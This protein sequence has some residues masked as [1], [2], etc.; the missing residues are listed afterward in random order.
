M[1]MQ[2]NRGVRFSRQNHSET[3]HYCPITAESLASEIKTCY[4][5]VDKGRM[6]LGRLY[7]KLR[8]HDDS[9]T[10]GSFKR[11]YQLLIE[12]DNLK[13]ILVSIAEK[14]SNYIRQ[15][16]KAQDIV[17]SDRREMEEFLRMNKATDKR[18]QEKVKIFSRFSDHPENLVTDLQENSQILSELLND[19]KEQLVAEEQFIRNKVRDSI[20]VSPRDRLH[21]IRSRRR[22]NAEWG[23]EDHPRE[24]DLSG[25]DETGYHPPDNKPRRGFESPHAVKDVDSP[26]IESCRRRKRNSFRSGEREE[27]A[28][29]LYEQ[30]LRTYEDRKNGQLHSRGVNNGGDQQPDDCDTS[31]LSQKLKDLVKQSENVQQLISNSNRKAEVDRKHDFETTL[32]AGLPQPLLP[33]E[34]FK[35]SAERKA[36]R[37]T[38]LGPTSV[39]AEQEKN[40][41]RVTARDPPLETKDNNP[42]SKLVKEFETVNRAGQDYAD[43]LQHRPDQDGADTLRRRPDQ[44]GADTLQHRSDQD[45][46]DAL[47]RRSDKDDLDTLQ[48]C[49][50]QDG[51]DTSRRSF[52]NF[53]QKCE[54]VERKMKGCSPKEIREKL[55]RNLDELDRADQ[56]VEGML[57]VPSL[58]RHQGH[59]CKGRVDHEYIRQEFVKCLD[60]IFAME[61]C[62][63]SAGDEIQNLKRELKQASQER[64]AV[65]Q[66]L[67][68]EIDKLKERLHLRANDVD[69]YRGRVYDLKKE[70]FDMKIKY[71]T[72]LAAK[73]EASKEDASKDAHNDDIKS[74]KD[75]CEHLKI[76]VDTKSNEISELRRELESAIE[77]IRNLKQEH[78]TGE[79]LTGGKLTGEKLTGEKV[80]VESVV[81]FEDVVSTFRR[82]NQESI[83][84]ELA[85]LQRV[86]EIA[87]ENQRKSFNEIASHKRENLHLIE[88][89]SKL[90]EETQKQMYRIEEL[91]LALMERNAEID[92]FYR[93][94]L[95]NLKEPEREYNA[96]DLQLKEAEC[97]RLKGKLAFYESMAAE[98]GQ[99]MTARIDGFYEEFVKSL[100]KINKEKEILEEDFQRQRLMY[101]DLLAE[102]HNEIS[103]L[104]KNEK[105]IEKI[106]SNFQPGKREILE[107][108]LSSVQNPE[109]LAEILSRDLKDGPIENRNLV[110]ENAKLQKANAE[111]QQKVEEAEQEVVTFKNETKSLKKRNKELNDKCDHLKSENYLLTRIRQ[112]DGQERL[113]T[114]KELLG[115]KEAECF[116][117]RKILDESIDYE[118][119]DEL[120]ERLREVHRELLQDGTTKEELSL[121]SLQELLEKRDREIR[122]LKR[123]NKLLAES[124]GLDEVG[125]RSILET[126]LATKENLM[127]YSSENVFDSEEKT[128]MIESENR[129]LKRQISGKSEE[130]SK[131]DDE[132]KVLKRS[133]K[134]SDD[135]CKVLEDEN[136][137][138]RKKLRTLQSEIRELD[139]LS[140]NRE[141]SLGDTANDDIIKEKE[142]LSE[143]LL[144]QELDNEK[145]ADEINGLKADIRRYEVEASDLKEKLVA[146]LEANDELADLKQENVEKDEILKDLSKKLGIVEKE[147]KTI[148]EAYIKQKVKN[149]ED[150]KHMSDQIKKLQ[151]EVASVTSK[152]SKSL[153]VDSLNASHESLPHLD[154][155]DGGLNR[156]DRNRLIKK[157]QEENHQQSA[158]ILSLEEET[159]AITKIVAD[160]E[161]GHGHLTGML[162]GHLVLQKDA[163]GKLLEK[164]LQQYSDEFESCKR[165]F[166][167][168]EDR[169]DKNRKHLTR[170]R[171]VWDL[172][173]NATATVDNITAILVEGLIKVEDDL[174]DEFSSDEDFEARD[175]K[176]RLWLLRR[177][178]DDVEKRYRDL[179][180]RA[181]ELSVRLDAKTAEYDVTQDEL[182]DATRVLEVNEITLARLTEELSA[183]AKE[184]AKLK[185]IMSQLKEN[186][187]RTVGA[188]I[189]ENEQLR[190][191][192]DKGAEDRTEIDALQL[193]MKSLQ[194]QLK[195]DDFEVR[196][197]RR[198]LHEQERREKEAIDDLKDKGREEARRY[199]EEA[200]KLQNEIKSSKKKAGESAKRVSEL[201]NQLRKA[202]EKVANLEKYLQKARSSCRSDGIDH[203]ST[204]HML[205]DDLKKLFKE[206][207]GLKDE[208]N[209]KQ[210][211]ITALAKD[212]REAKV[213]VKE[214]LGTGRSF[215]EKVLDRAAKDQIMALKRRI[216]VLE[217]EN[218]K[219]VRKVNNLERDQS[220]GEVT[221]KKKA[222]TAKSSLGEKGGSSSSFSKDEDGGKT[223]DS[224]KIA[225][226]T[227]KSVS[228][229]IFGNEELLDNSLASIESFKDFS[230]ENKEEIEIRDNLIRELEG[231][232]K[233]LKRELAKK[234]EDEKTSVGEK[235]DQTS[236]QVD[237]MSISEDVEV[238]KRE[239]AKL[240]KSLEK[241]K[242]L[243]ISYQVRQKDD[244]IK[245]LRAKLGELDDEIDQKDKKL[246]I[247]ERELAQMRE[248]LGPDWK[249]KEIVL[250]DSDEYKELE[251]QRDREMK[252]LKEEIATLEATC[253]D[254]RIAIE[255]L[256]KGLAVS[257]TNEDQIQAI[258]EISVEGALQNLPDKDSG[259]ADSASKRSPKF[260]AI[261]S[262]EQPASESYGHKGKGV[263]RIPIS[264]RPKQ[265][266]TSPGKAEVRKDLERKVEEQDDDIK[267]LLQSVDYFEKEVQK[268]IEEVDSLKEKLKNSGDEIKLL[269][270]NNAKLQSQLRETK[271][272]DEKLQ[273]LEENVKR[274]NTENKNLEQQ[275]KN[276]R[277]AESERA[278]SPTELSSRKIAS[279]EKELRTN[280]KLMETMKSHIGLF[281]NEL[282][283]DSIDLSDDEKK[284]K[285]VIGESLQKRI[286]R[287]RTTIQADAKRKTEVADKENEKL[288]AELNKKSNSLD[289]HAENIVTLKADLLDTEKE[290]K[291]IRSELEK[292]KDR[293]KWLEAELDKAT[294]RSIALEAI[295]EAVTHS[296]DLQ[297]VERKEKIAASSR[298]LISA[299]NDLKKVARGVFVMADE[300][301]LPS[302]T[303]EEEVAEEIDKMTSLI[304]GYS[305]NVIDE[306]GE[307]R[308]ANFELE[309]RV[310]EFRKIVEETNSKISALEEEVSE[311]DKDDEIG[312]RLLIDQITAL[313]KKVENCEKDKRSIEDEAQRREEFIERLTGQVKILEK[314]IAQR[315]TENSE[316]TE[317]ALDSEEELEH[318]KT[319]IEELE[320]DYNRLLHHGMKLDNEEAE[321]AAKK[322]EFEESL[323]KL[324]ATIESLK[325][326][327]KYLEAK[328]E[329]L[330]LANERKN[331]SG[332]DIKS[333]DHQLLKD[334]I[335]RLE[336]DREDLQARIH[337]LLEH[338]A[339]QEDDSNDELK[340]NQKKVKSLEDAVFRL[341]LEKAAQQKS[342]DETVQNN[343]KN[344]MDLKMKISELEDENSRMEEAVYQLDVEREGLRKR[345]NELTS[346]ERLGDVNDLTLLL[347]D[348]EEKIAD[349]EQEK[350]VLQ[351]KQEDLQKIIDNILQ[352]PREEMEDDIGEDQDILKGGPQSWKRRLIAAYRELREK[353]TELV[354]MKMIVESKNV[355]VDLL[356]KEASEETISEGAISLSEDEKSLR[357]N[358]HKQ[359]KG[360]VFMLQEE[361]RMK[362]AEI[363]ELKNEI[364]SLQNQAQLQD[365]TVDEVTWKINGK[366]E[367]ELK[368][369]ELQKELDHLR[370]KL[371][372]KD[373][374]Y[375]A[376][377]D[378]LFGGEPLVTSAETAELKSEIGNLREALAV[379]DKERAEMDE[380][381]N[382]I[383][384]ELTRMK[385]DID[386]GAYGSGE[387]GVDIHGE[388]IKMLQTSL[389]E[390]EEK[391]RNMAKDFNE[392]EEK[393]GEEM[394]Y[395]STHIGDLMLQ[396]SELEGQLQEMRDNKRSGSG[397]NEED[398]ETV[399]LA[400]ESK[401]KN[402]ED[403]LRRKN[404]LIENMKETLSTIYED[405]ADKSGERR[406]INLH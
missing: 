388:R 236:K 344:T 178:L 374:Q 322:D 300:D 1:A 403:E 148:N 100:E 115:K 13:D 336:L 331:K 330:T 301:L 270:T 216:K 143:K 250:L 22:T 52:E 198:R 27:K 142:Y 354:M 350:K 375:E 54:E 315:E 190:R 147:R 98:E 79:K 246:K 47:R 114:Y 360:T 92:D 8:Q 48:P 326:D 323:R 97:Q 120:L 242:D 239:N 67:R 325:E 82:S 42:K 68:E 104:T 207:E 359:L 335:Y 232:V 372:E 400:I 28:L 249:T 195:L 160:M 24:G 252:D 23:K 376:L 75:E 356:S 303:N 318:L 278:K 314:Q 88:E 7:D 218:A 377:C 32:K 187:E 259:F 263:S 180:L 108:L 389:E 63:G 390:S 378:Q 272:Q 214:Q 280:K 55:L 285:R 268:K 159:T 171:F 363:K 286:R 76:K 103:Q 213:S 334:T 206:N 111:L 362:T 247:Y 399:L 220:L 243:P 158:R 233:E 294:A 21:Y 189:A 222:P 90:S 224:T 185:G 317:R 33:K 6:L 371:S 127:D 170:R 298:H 328:V 3:G 112:D 277:R 149:E 210:K 168:I 396:V 329:D 211:Q 125:R 163:T 91:E 406:V 274:L 84:E 144:I 29:Q 151:N 228:S 235:N 20:S 240:K 113:K 387:S 306:L 310:E 165:K 17:W 93:K 141:F 9:K 152:H 312:H 31:S 37:E 188:V 134:R 402:S 302:S 295:Q 184:N 129:I 176:S 191:E 296:D 59:H 284:A 290:R 150:T 266:R 345:I 169:Y 383:Y 292:S 281:K 237:D 308:K 254:Q 83:S 319:R 46:K 194:D 145:L 161:R 102:C 99:D 192:I 404:K 313:K 348:N 320:D 260:I 203:H 25:H 18:L 361:I 62:Y 273:V 130:A 238:L 346:D 340:E 391:Y 94:D 39:I 40:T 200:S 366:R 183:S 253:E 282:R 66:S 30:D 123:Q 19:L 258:S 182:E 49:S 229:G 155:K 74:L 109:E 279:L 61:K 215:D 5:T 15:L 245:R 196:E 226:D 321:A 337:E 45:G 81:N 221:K 14:R 393:Y 157:L 11:D 217:M 96:I 116:R 4:D 101:E 164:S 64:D 269:K 56:D 257:Q 117:L 133:L 172:F 395:A 397:T 316:L 131:L 365:G 26:T 16:E 283:M 212:L 297:D 288:R 353:S 369:E 110:N 199:E 339:R 401:L 121:E 36:E 80:S 193:E 50:D 338:V 186:Q 71:E 209:N 219:L 327:K 364:S 105:K 166:K 119:R 225:D 382:L 248:K 202:E 135:Q 78:H 12:L 153:A 231:R 124:L 256:E 332:E 122:R 276:Y 72:E 138:L 179:M 261:N 398:R 87:E 85:A 267:T 118:E 351:A 227:V 265:G 255:M 394:N 201:E 60:K 65:E 347:I 34:Y 262:K 343:E 126:V 291:K 381:Y 367:E 355:E 156:Y 349:L 197:M 333:D 380:N 205:R 41:T 107:T 10:L 385:A 373:E 311:K 341:E 136:N 58:L 271:A 154:E 73:E 379:N 69:F 234:T 204:I 89:N 358:T 241:Q 230:S 70:L 137:S 146:S 140:S 309:N 342:Y 357:R 57:R 251:K 305:K 38:D 275:T 293:I 77:E 167:A 368:A 162:R 384:N 177:R 386:S 370:N 51:S 304:A 324:N 289:K 95:R 307:Q 53:L 287:E 392:L 352:S 2:Q 44:D 132:V 43:N 223:E 175:Y 181:E 128:K 106:M 244:V 264:P 173:E 405:T 86:V 35:R 299:W 208:M 139:L 174:H